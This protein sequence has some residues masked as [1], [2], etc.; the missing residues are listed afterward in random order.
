MAKVRKTRVKSK[1]KAAGKARSASKKTTSKR[2]KAGKKAAKKVAGKRAGKALRVSKKTKP[3]A[4]EVLEESPE[5]ANGLHSTAEDMARRQREI[6]VAEFFMK[7]RH[8]LGFD[9]PRKALLTTIKE[10]VDNSLDACEEAGIL[11]EVRIAIA[12]GAEENRFRVTLE[13]NGPGILR[14]QIPK[15]SLPS[16]STARNFTGSRCPAGSRASASR[17]P[18]CMANSQRASLSSSPPRPPAISR[19]TTMSLRSTPRRTNP[20]SWWMKP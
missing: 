10:G 12:S 3:K 9:N 17:R 15:R 5:Q 4:E 11:P 7:N 18:A 19:P 1:H 14:K 2:K 16:C 13:D 20:A 6:S 8:L